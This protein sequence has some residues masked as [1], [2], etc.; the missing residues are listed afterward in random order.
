[1]DRPELREAEILSAQLVAK[2]SQK[3]TANGG[4]V[5]KL[6]Y[7][8]VAMWTMGDAPVLVDVMLKE[9]F[10]QNVPSPDDPNVLYF[11]PGLTIA[12]VIQPKSDQVVYLAPGALV[13]G[14]IEAKNVRSVRVMGRGLLET[15]GYSV[16][17]EQL[18]GILFDQARNVTV[19]GIGVR[20]YDT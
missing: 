7:F 4:S 16:R 17:N 8:D 12:G 20:S 15:E 2:I 18:H 13:Q 1:M 6:E 11:K 5:S 10:E 14:R 19:E 9:S 3:D